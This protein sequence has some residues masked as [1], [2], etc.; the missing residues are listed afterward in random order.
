MSDEQVRRL[1]ARHACGL[2]TVL[3]DRPRTRP[4]SRKSTPRIP[5]PP[6]D[7]WEKFH[8]IPRQLQDQ[9]TGRE[10][11]RKPDPFITA[12]SHVTMFDVFIR[13]DDLF[14]GR[15]RYMAKAEM[16]KW[17]LIGKWFQLVGGVQRS[18]GQGQ[19]DRRDLD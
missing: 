12:A 3:P 14:M 11:V 6:N 8:C 5:R 9:G 16:A 10:Q 17:P 13:N 4:I 15:R 19:A 2:D 18:F 7:C 1:A